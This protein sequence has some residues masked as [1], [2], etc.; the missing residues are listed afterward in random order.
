MLQR[1][2]QVQIQRIA[3]RVRLGLLRTHLGDAAMVGQVSARTILQQVLVNV[4]QRQ[5]PDSLHAP[6]RELEMIALRHHVARLR[7]QHHHLLEILKIFAR[8]LA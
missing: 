3:E 6:G 5:L 1:R 8:L 7:Q 2:D 4:A